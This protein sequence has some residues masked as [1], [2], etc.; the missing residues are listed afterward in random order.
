MADDT[1]N[2]PT[3]PQ[4]GGSQTSDA[5]ALDDLTLLNG[6]NPNDMGQA[7]LNV[8]RSIDATE[9]SLNTLSAVHQGAPLT[10]SAAQK[11]SA[12]VG[13]AIEVEVDD[14]ATAKRG[15]STDSGQ[16]TTGAS[17]Q[18]LGVTI[19][20]T[21]AHANVQAPYAPGGSSS[22]NGPG[23]APAPD[24]GTGNA[25][26]AHGPQAPTASGSHQAAAGTAT[27]AAAGANADT[28][29]AGATGEQQQQQQIHV[30]APVTYGA[31]I[32][33]ADSTGQED[34]RIPLTLNV[35]DGHA[36]EGISDV[37]LT[38]GVPGGGT[39]PAGT[40]LTVGGEI[41][42]AGPDGAFHLS[43]AQADDP[44]LA[45]NPPTGFA[46]EIDVTVSAT[47]DYPGA[48]SVTTS[49]TFKVEVVDPGPKVAPTLEAGDEGHASLTGNVGATAPEGN[50]LAYTVVG[51]G[52]SAGGG[53]VSV[54]AHGTYTY[55]PA[56]NWQAGHSDTFQ[57]QVTDNYG[58][59]STQ[60]VTIDLTDSGPTVTS[61][62]T[63][64]DDGH[65]SLAGNV[66]AAGQSGDSISYAVVGDGTTTHGT[67]SVGTD[68]GYT[69]HVTDANWQA[70]QTD[71]FQVQVS[72]GHGGTTTQTV[73]VNLTD[74]GPTAPTSLGV[75][76]RG[77][78]DGNLGAK[79]SLD[80]LT[81]TITDGPAHG[82]A[83]VDQNGH[84]SYT[85]S[86]ASWQ[87][88]DKDSFT[89]QVSDGHGGVVT[90]TVKVTDADT[91]PTVT[92]VESSGD[93]HAGVSGGAGTTGDGLTYALVGDGHTTGGG[94][95]NVGAD[96]QYTYTPAEDWKAGQSDSFQIQVSDGHGG[97]TTQTVTVDLT[98]AG[99][100][101]SATVSQSNDGHVSL[102]ANVDAGGQTG[103]SLS[104]AVVGD[105]HTG[106]GGTVSVGPDGQY[107][108]TPA[109]NWKA[110]QT[111]NFQ[112]EVSDGHGGTA[113]Q[114]V[115]VHLT[116]AGPSVYTAVSG[117]DDGHDSLYGNVGA[118]PQ[119]GDSMTYTVVGDG[120]T[121]HGTVSVDSDGTYV[122]QVT[123][124]KWQA[125]EHDS[126]QVQV[127]DG[128]GGTTTQ[129]VT[130][131]L[132]DAGPTVSDAVAQGHG[133]A[134]G[135]VGATASV[136]DTLGYTVSE[137][138]AH[139]TVTVDGDGNYHYADTNANW[140]AGDKDSFTVQVSDGH[141]GTASETVT[142]TDTNTAPTIS[143]IG[144]T[145]TYG[146]ATV[147]GTISDANGDALTA[148][149]ST[150]P[151][152]G[153]I[154]VD[155]TG[156]H[157]TDTNATWQAGDTDSFTI[158]ASDGHGGVTTETVTVTDGSSPATIAA[159]DATGH[160]NGS[161]P[162]HLGVSD[163]HEAITDVSLT[164]SVPGGGTLPAG[165]T[166]TVGGEIVQAGADGTFH[167]TAAQA[168]DSTLAINPPTGFA[169]QIDVSVTATADNPGLAPVT[170]NNSFTVE[171]ADP[172]AKLAPTVETGD[173][174]H[175]TLTGNV[176]ATAPEG[177]TLDYAVVG[178]G[179]SANGGT[180]SVDAAGNYTY[181][182]A[183]G[184]QANQTDSF[185]V[186]V[187]D[188]YGKTSTQTVSVELTDKG[189]SFANVA[190][191]DEGHATLSGSIGD[192]AGAGDTVSYTA[193]EHGATALGGS[194][195]VDAAGNYS[196][197]PAADW[198]AGQ[199]DSF[200]V[201]V[202]DGHGGTTTQTVSVELTD[203]G[204]VMPATASIDTAENKAIAGSVG[205]T[206]GGHDNLSYALTTDGHPAHGSVS[207]D[208]QGGYTYTPGTGF[209]GNDHFSVQVSDGHGGTTTQSISVEV[210]APHVTAP[211]VHTSDIT[212]DLSQ[213]HQV[214]IVGTSGNDV[215]NGVAGN[216]SIG[217]GDGND[218][219]YGVGANTT[220]V[221]LNVGDSLGASPDHLG[222]VTISG[223]PDGATL[224]AG[225]HSNG[226]WTLTPDQ[227]G[228]LT[229]T[230]PVG[231]DVHLQVSAT[232]IGQTG[233]SAT[234]SATLN[235]HFTGVGTETLSGGGGD[236]TIYAGPGNDT[237][238]GGNG[239]DLLVG[240][241]GNDTF[242]YNS[243]ST[244][245]GG[246]Y[247]ENV[248]DP[249]HGGPNTL[250]S[251]NGYGQ[252]FDAFQGVA[253][254]HNTIVMGDG[255]KA[256]FLDDSYSPEGGGTGPRLINIQEVDA[257]TGNQVIDM[258]SPSYSV[259]DM[260][261]IGGNGSDVLMTSG[262]NDVIHAG[263]GDSYLWGGSGN[264]TLYGS[265]GNDTLIGGSG[266]DTIYG[267]TGND[268]GV[269]T[270][271]TG[272]GGVYD[273]GGGTN[274]FQVQLTG[275][276]YTQAVRSELLAFQT[277]IADPSH[278]G[279]TF[280][281]NT[282]GV[283]AKNWEGLKVTVDGSDISLEHAPVDTAG[284]A[285]DTVRGGTTTGTFTAT[286]A[287]GDATT[288]TATAGHGTVTVNANGTYSYHET[289]KGFVG[290][291]TV[292]FTTT[293]GH[294]GST[295]ATATVAV[296]DIGPV[297]VAGAGTDTV[298]GGTATGTIKATDADGDALTTTATAGHG[299][300]TVNADGTYTY[301]ETDKG[302]VGN[303]TLTFTTTDGHGG[304]TTATA[305]VAVKDIGPV[306][307]AGNA[308]DTAR[309][310]TTTG[311]FKAT[312][313][314]GDALTTTATAGHGTVTVNTDGTYSYHETDTTFAGKDT[315][316]FTTTDGHGG[317][318]T[319][320][321]TVNV[322][323]PPV[324][325]AS[326][327][328]GT[329]ATAGS[330]T[331]QVV[332]SDAGYNNT[333]GYYVTDSNGHPTSGQILFGNVKDGGNVTIS[334][335]DPNHVGFF[336]IPNGAGNTSGLTN[337]EHVTFAQVGGQ[338]EALDPSG[339]VLGGTG[340][341]V[342]FDDKSL[343]GDQLTHVEDTGTDSGNQNW[344]DLNGGGDRDYNDVNVSVSWNQ[345]HTTTTFPLTIA[346]TPGDSG[347]SLTY[348]VS[349]LTSG[350]KLMVGTTALTPDASGAYTLT[351]D[352]IGHVSVV[353]PQD[354]NGSLGLQ[355]TVTGHDGSVVT[356]ASQS[357]SS[358][359]L[360]DGDHAP[361]AADQAF[362]GTHAT[363]SIGGAIVASDVD[364]DHLHYSLD[365]THLAG[366]GSVVLNTDGTFTYTAN[367]G[368]VGADHFT[369]TVADGR[370]GSTSETV[371]V[372]V[373]DTAP[374]FSQHSADSFSHLS[375]GKGGATD[376]GKAWW[377][378][379]A[380]G[381][382]G[383]L[384][385]GTSG[386]DVLT[387]DGKQHVVLGM[388]GNDT[389][390]TGAGADTVYANDGSMG[391]GTGHYQAQLHISAGS[392]DEASASQMSYSIGGIPSHVSLVDASGN[393]LDAGHVTD[394]QIS[395]GVYLSFPD[396]HPPASFDLAVSANLTETDG[397]VATAQTS[398][399]VDTSALMGGSDV[400]STGAGN[401]VVVGGAGND[402]IST[403]TGDDKIYTYDGNN[404]ID[405]G[406]GND[407]VY[408]GD[409]NNSIT[410]DHGNVTVGSG[411]DTVNYGGGGGNSSGGT[412][413]NTT[414]TG[415]HNITLV[416]NSHGTGVETLTVHGTGSGSD[417]MMFDFSGH[418]TVATG[419]TGSNWT[420]TIDL[421]NHAGVAGQANSTLYIV[422][423]HGNSWTEAADA[424]GTV[425][426][427]KTNGQQ[428]ISGHVY[429]DAAHT[430]E[431]V[432]FHNIEKISF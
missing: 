345:A 339:K 412:V 420:D 410:L 46:G 344:E 322:D 169:G 32:T 283:D 157:Y 2:A 168:D 395:G 401:D 209:Y 273:G 340:A 236:D 280:H 227:L 195:S 351:A 222:T 390:T 82:S 341:N 127:S 421:T 268:L 94:T 321:A 174:G 388:G 53:T 150:G 190:T 262:G 343:N 84:F 224:S 288:T 34:T 179:H 73:T 208:G 300:V 130:V 108:Y 28:G 21:T 375:D 354:F 272:N 151:A 408:A 133:I 218:I 363:A 138:P 249:G 324:L 201:Q 386:D 398:M 361:V 43:A 185:Q 368:F 422:D 10:V 189:P 11:G 232:E 90:E 156:I 36:G 295:T 24:I 413:V 121:A 316:S 365:T 392:P 186:Q 140:Q 402:T 358:A 312:D 233:D 197:T 248:G 80:P 141:G 103:D 5:Q 251:I 92:G 411:T 369:V 260:T 265:A 55:T 372:T 258:T 64:G 299:T 37:T 276:Q 65:Y 359:A 382:K 86:N 206:N 203:K 229:M 313:A 165:T 370:G 306:D 215:I 83:S 8:M 113:T 290:N 199:H 307:V 415:A 50:T 63:K 166:L 423:N 219:I 286:D 416:D 12:T 426:L 100:A 334:G 418:D 193:V 367:S 252:S 164:L 72:D 255:N 196:Y 182:P 231:T 301:H 47:A 49:D 364:G 91:A 6:V 158:Q 163:A 355:V 61:A 234:G 407:T 217:G 123:D 379:Y 143:N 116:D 220:T 188:N 96:G 297:D 353:T 147:T 389:I 261:L 120:T 417:T 253:G 145:S 269:F 183:P 256:L 87:A 319:A 176:G 4:T 347:Q 59:T 148:S 1:N 109:E 314:D 296:K 366:H 75:E 335:V 29:T 352:Q 327:G 124:S 40:T 198:K 161:I 397:S 27:E 30:Q 425:D 357:L 371:T 274:T 9:S 152:H 178:D 315:I 216:E 194:V 15:G 419:A 204:P 207:F 117:S 181:T 137:G 377:G 285:A 381:S 162:L 329:N 282:L 200:T 115:T 105:G 246:W 52:H 318:A 214:G 107:T 289:D 159:T 311:T 26:G 348:S 129:T 406:T 292:T 235:V 136:A 51:D 240:G 33:A 380:G 362:S 134:D 409:G 305:T 270:A 160:E 97:T 44:T 393:V 7:R 39:L 310:G 331:A 202:S 432:E 281:F 146:G 14:T 254:G 404:V 66:G 328:A 85:D 77:A 79:D 23:Q 326:L 155:D 287:D 41:I 264:D 250:F 384:V 228:G 128:H 122:Y 376:G 337:G 98:D 172:G 126:F 429:T 54:D 428:D 142:V 184:W 38:L 93:G 342:L 175:A 391:N 373:G 25:D 149:I 279:Q 180:V 101:V 338:W 247:S 399:H 430:H 257:G 243:D 68:G 336:I 89:V 223:V 238:I 294:G 45:I 35:S 403:G 330:F 17:F 70:G 267:G 400:I 230:A 102:S 112:V 245:S 225:A 62:V 431:V 394:A 317:S 187:T 139:G 58:K 242:I 325:T 266:M 31:D 221:A 303:D 284:N 81:Y 22:A 111:D 106:G 378:G 308:A 239:A 275:G 385:T 153:T 20:D 135:N 191:T 42:H 171:V 56:E 302:F 173:E 309:G 119:S 110:G 211:V 383:G 210:D 48:A 350:A 88:G 104:Y 154:S 278:A 99:P 125:G 346:A 170:T 304:S 132:T 263:T 226:V 205:V 414:G 19:A 67:V 323:P 333:Y 291:D 95:V 213:T 16:T 3:G 374:T 427:A 71:S 349:G 244:W 177:N 167:L 131:N 332:G 424:H 298:R 356:T 387:T 69:Y 57:V 320:T 277:F 144:E 13:A 259:G 18:D 60:T 118:A 114:T 271:G 293:D 396:N 360:A 405:A 78:V 76:G 74:A 241:H 212:V 192:V 237:L